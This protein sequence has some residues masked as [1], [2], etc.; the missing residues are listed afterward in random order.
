MA[1]SKATKPS[2]K[3]IKTAKKLHKQKESGKTVY[4][5]GARSN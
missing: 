1:I 5:D 3:E 2:K 4:K